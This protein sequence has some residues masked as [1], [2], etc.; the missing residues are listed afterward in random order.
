MDYIVGANIKSQMGLLAV[1]FSAFGFKWSSYLS[2]HCSDE[3]RCQFFFNFE[4]YF[5]SQSRSIGH[6]NLMLKKCLYY[7][8]DLIMMLLHIRNHSA[9]PT[10]I[11]L[12][13]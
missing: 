13:F 10:Q 12:H 2:L 1:F 8:P 11:T 4:D 7:K 5:Y 6:E 9:N 3:L